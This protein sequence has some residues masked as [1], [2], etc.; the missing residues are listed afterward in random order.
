MK[1]GTIKTLGAAAL[2]VAFAAAAAGTASAAP[3]TSA[4]PSLPGTDGAT[5]AVGNIT[6]AAPD[7]VGKTEDAIKSAPNTLKAALPNTG[8]QG[9]SGL[10]GG[11]QAG[12]LPGAD[13][14]G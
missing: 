9:N 10:L 11:L 13:G 2:G 1:T 12:Q 8:N 6:K 5:S 14:L 4:L 7:Q 3:V